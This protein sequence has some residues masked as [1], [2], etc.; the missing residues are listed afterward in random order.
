MKRKMAMMRR[1]K[2]SFALLCRPVKKAFQGCRIPLEVT[3]AFPAAL[4]SE[5]QQHR[6]GQIQ[7]ATAATAQWREDLDRRVRRVR[8]AT[9]SQSCPAL[10][11]R[12]DY[13][14][15]TQPP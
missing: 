2:S 15:K 9:D 11:H 1:W 13:G 8:T 10:A 5:K 3:D 12:K 4:P 6:F 7:E 14:F